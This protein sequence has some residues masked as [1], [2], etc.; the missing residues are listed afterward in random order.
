MCAAGKMDYQQMTQWV[1]TDTLTKAQKPQVVKGGSKG[2]GAPLKVKAA[3]L[4]KAQKPQGVEGGS[5]GA[6]L[7]VKALLDKR[8]S[9]KDKDSERLVE[10]L[11]R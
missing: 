5:K 9:S 3:S 2:A 1:M 7:T 6:P 4:T 10:M 11:L 8:A